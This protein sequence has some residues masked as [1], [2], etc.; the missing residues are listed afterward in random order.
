M[1]YRIQQARSLSG[2]VSL[3][4]DKS[5]THRALLL[6]AIAEGTALVRGASTGA[7]C[8]STVACLKALGADIQEGEGHLL[9]RG[10]GLRS[11]RE[12]G[13][14]LN[15]GNS[16]TTLRLL[17]GML[18]GIEPWLVVI[19][20]DDSLRSRPVD[21]V[22]VPLRLMGADLWARGGDRFAP[23]AIRG[24][25]LR[26]I[27]YE[28]PVAS[29]QLKSALLLAGLYA[30]GETVI[31]EP[32]PSRDHTERLLKAM[33]AT[34]SIEGREVH[35]RPSKLRAV[36][37]QVPGDVSAAAFWLV[38]GAVHPQAHITIRNVGLNPTRA[39]IIQ[40]LQAMGARLQ[41]RN[42]REESGEP[43]ADLEIESSPLRAIEI[44]GDLIP[45]LIDELPVLA[46]AACFAEGKTVI[47]D[48]Q[49]LRV[50]ESD[51][52]SA[53]VRELNRLGCQLEERP[54][55]M[56]I[57]GN[58]GIRGAVCQSYGDHRIAM[59]L[60]IA[61]LVAK[62]ETAIEGAEAVEVSYPGFWEDLERLST[63]GL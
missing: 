53:T 30:E 27:R 19:T 36:D 10:E 18:A 22:I 61:G 35:L 16:G 15:A 25:P 20:G 7:D 60:A 57:Q 52:I 59:M 45:Q 26:G 21:R 31:Q 42:Q 56:V 63:G 9:V 39:G 23:L 1:R 62:G 12:P 38:A 44:E 11:L 37:I 41:I 43:V 50:K 14:V 58:Q 32:S 55:G 47:R 48:A 40:V 54:D 29:A 5:I 46:L 28:T 24:S 3:P 49:E 13:E 34:I 6:N 33:G 4:G 2:E 17:T 51:R 8:L